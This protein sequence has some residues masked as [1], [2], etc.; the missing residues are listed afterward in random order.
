MAALK[1]KLI[2]SVALFVSVVL[3][4]LVSNVQSEGGNPFF[5]GTFVGTCYQSGVAKSKI[6]I[7]KVDSVVIVHESFGCLDLNCQPNIQLSYFYFDVS[8]GLIP[9]KQAIWYSEFAFMTAA[10]YDIAGCKVLQ[11]YFSSNFNMTVFFDPLFMRAFSR[12][13]IDYYGATFMFTISTN[14][15]SNV[16]Q[17]N[18]ERQIHNYTKDC[19]FVNH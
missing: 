16:I 9:N 7:E 13:D 12:T 2:M 5:N 4:A 10:C 3:F 17:M 15:L 6:T 14:T 1:G 11:S 8:Y 19:R 18:G